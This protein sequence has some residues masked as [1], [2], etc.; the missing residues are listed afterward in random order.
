MKRW[1]VVLGLVAV[2]ASLVGGGAWYYLLRDVPDPVQDEETLFKYGSIGAEGTSLPTLIWR[3]LPEVCSDLLPGGYAS[4]G[5]L[6]EPGADRPIG[7][8]EHTVGVP[9]AAFN[10]STCHVSTVR[11]T[12]SAPPQIILGMS[13]HRFDVQ[14]Y[15][16]FVTSCIDSDR[17]TSDT[18][19]PAIDRMA[20][21]SGF[22]RALYRYAIIPGTK[23][24][25]RAIKARFAWFDVRPD[26]G[27]GRFDG[28]N[29][30]KPD[31]SHDTSI[32]TTDFPSLWQQK[33]RD[34]QARH[35]D[36]IATTLEE[37]ALNSAL[38][39]GATPKSLNI[40]ALQRVVRYVE[41]L[42]A[43]RYP[44]PI[45][46]VLAARGKPVYDAYCSECHE[47]GAEKHGKVTDI[48]TIGTDP[49]RM[50]AFTPQLADVINAQGEGYPWKF[51][52]Y[53]HSTGYVNAPLDGIW[54]RAPYLHNGSVPTLR[55]LLSPV[56][57]RPKAYDRGSDVYDAVNVGFVSD[58]AAD[59]RAL[60]RF[61]TTAA[62]NGNGGHVYGV[63]LPEEDKAALLEYLKTR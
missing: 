14:R 46:N 47:A 22:E 8:T 56:A 57:E 19:M 39:V 21:L 59:P 62:G 54:A 45:D 18:V 38:G 29:G 51:S 63:D 7:I 43:P 37:G 31:I 2:A 55:A 11:A 16:R 15:T 44:F 40:E 5:F 4:L 26:F 25:V 9:R 53:H 33:Q 50:E 61:D 30:Y 35:W 41:R 58:R 24:E 20:Q 49:C 1:L 6:Y 23:R 3:A 52:G 36:G 12:P 28:I 48:A 42:P 34:G 60:F 13:A 17:F 32:G 27:P 10:C